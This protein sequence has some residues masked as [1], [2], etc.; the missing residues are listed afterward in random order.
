MSAKGPGWRSMDGLVWLAR[1]GPAPAGTWGAAMGWAPQTVRSHTVRLQRAGLL[2]RVAR[3]Q[4][5]GGALVYASA[6]GVDTAR[7]RAGVQALA[8]RR[9]PAPVTWQHIEACA[10]MAAYLTVR[11]REMIAPRELLLDDR[12]LGQV[13][14]TEHDET[15]RRGHRPDL[16]ATGA[17]GRSVA[18]EVELTVKSAQRLR[19]VLSMYVAWL[20]EGRVESLL[21]AVGSELERRAVLRHAPDVGLELGQRFGVRPLAQMT[22]DEAVAA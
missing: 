6:F 12:W 13:E 20:A 18:I 4:S 3:L 2:E 21:Y 9:P 5:A 11:G 19:S 1:V 17:S 16:V 22:A 7:A 14:W 15:R 8:L 10:Q